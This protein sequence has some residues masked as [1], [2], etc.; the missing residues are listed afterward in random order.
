MRWSTSRLPNHWPSS[1]SARVASTNVLRDLRVAVRWQ[2]DLGSRG[3]GGPIGAGL[4]TMRE[5]TRQ[6]DVLDC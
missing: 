1:F 4:A 6:D 3:L 5:L 2:K